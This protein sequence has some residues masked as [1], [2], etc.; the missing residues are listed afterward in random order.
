MPNDNLA[1]VMSLAV[2]DFNLLIFALGVATGATAQVPDQIALA[3]LI[4]ALTRRII[5][6]KR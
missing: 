1:V 5:D 6:A 3:Q 2:E 4:F